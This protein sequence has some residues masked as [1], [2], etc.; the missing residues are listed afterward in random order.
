MTTSGGREARDGFWFQDAMILLRL[1][2]DGLD[3]RA[4]QG[5]GESAPLPLRIA[6]E[7]AAA[8]SNATNG[9][10]WDAITYAASRAYVDSGIVL[11]EMKK[12]DIAKDDRIT[13]WRRL[14]RTVAEGIDATT[15][16]PRLSLGA[17]AVANP[18]KWR[19]L[20]HAAAAVVPQVTDTVRDAAD[21][22][23]E[24]LWCLTCRDDNM[25]GWPAALEEAEARALLARFEFDDSQT[26]DSLH[27]ALVK[28]L[29]QIGA[30]TDPDVLVR[31]LRGWIAEVAC[32]PDADAVTF[33]DAVEHLELLRRYLILSPQAEQLWQR[34]RTAVP[35]EPAT[36]LAVQDWRV[37]Q[38][39]AAAAIESRTSPLAIVAPAGQGKSASL[40]ALVAERRREGDVG[41]WLDGTEPVDC[42]TLREAITFGR[43]AAG[44]R[45]RRV[46]I[47]IDGIDVDNA[48][49]SL[50]TASG[51]IAA[52]ATDAT[53]RGA[54]TDDLG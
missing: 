5:V 32:D 36:C 50:A 43:W 23:A 52:D 9:T 54:A 26:V 16:V 39:N 19:G 20:A 37:V 18:D 27:G 47:V 51:A 15:I 14:R 1:L 8:A 48:A 29:R 21:L 40:R 42:A 2:N 13:F 22:A 11:D 49:S 44:R 31:Q 53:S 45:G 24:A 41:T 28:T 30:D 33:E 6:I 25:A 35:P 10:A 3:R 4:L 34:M 38:P 12:G 46:L 17:D 7:Q